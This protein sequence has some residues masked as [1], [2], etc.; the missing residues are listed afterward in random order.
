MYKCITVIILCLNSINQQRYRLL[1]T[2]LKLW[3][4]SYKMPA[5]YE[6]FEIYY[7]IYSVLWKCQQDRYLKRIDIS[8]NKSGTPDLLII[9][10]TRFVGTKKANSFLDFKFL[11]VINRNFEQ[12]REIISLKIAVSMPGSIAKKVPRLQKK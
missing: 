3:F 12:I 2:Y 11:T 8:Q 10:C 5:K 9:S 6:I 7:F 1:E 4:Y